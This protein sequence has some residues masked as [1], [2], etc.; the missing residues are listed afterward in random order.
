MAPVN[1]PLHSA[2]RVRVDGKFFRAGTA[3][4]HPRGVAY[5]PLGPNDHGEVF[6]TP[7]ATLRDFGL[8]RALG[9]NVI[10]IYAVPPAWFMDLA[11]AHEL[12]L[13]VD[14][15]WNQRACVLD[16]AASRRRVRGQIHQAAR[17]CARHPAIF[18][19]SVA[20]ELPPD[21]VRWSGP[22]PMEQFLEE[23]AATVKGA[24]PE[25]L[26]TFGNYPT[27]EYLNPRALDFCCFNVYLHDRRALRQYLARLQTLAGE[28]PLL[29]GEFGMD[30]RRE[31]AERQARLLD[32]TIESGFRAGL[33]G[34]IAYTF[35]DEWFKDGQPITDWEFGLTTRE[36]VPRPAFAT[37]QAAYRV[38]PYFPARSEPL[39]SVVVASYNGSRLLRPCLESLAALNYPA[40]EVILVDDGSTDDTP[41][42]AAQYPNVRWIRH[43]RNRG[44]SAARN[45]G[46]AAARGEIVAF[47]DD[48]C[49]VDEDWLHH[50]VGELI[51]SGFAGVG[52][53]NL[54]PGEDSSV[55]AAVLVSP[56]GPTHVMLTDRLAEHIPGC[57]MAFWKSALIEIGCFDPVFT[58]AGD[59]VDLCWRLQQQGLQLG[60]SPGGF[61]WHARRATVRAYLRQQ[62]GYGEAEA[63]LAAKHPEYFNPLG[64]SLWRGQIYTHA[65]VGLQVQRPMIYHGRFGA[66]A[67]QSLYA[68]SPSLAVFVFT[69]LEF[70][71][72]V[73][74]PLLVLS[75]VVGWL[76][77]LA[78]ACVAA[79]V[80]VCGVAA[81]QAV[82]P[83]GKERFWSRPLVGLLYMLQPLVRGWARYQGRLFPSRTS[84]ARRENLDSLSRKQA[85][86]APRLMDFEDVAYRGRQAFL[87]ALVER[88]A[89]DNWQYRL[90]TGWGNW[91]LEVYGDR[92]SK[93][94]IIT[95]AEQP[96]E[97]WRRV[98]C[99]LSTSW[100]LP[101]K[102]AYGLVLAAALLAMAL[103][104]AQ[105]WL[106][107]IPLVA[108]AL[109][110]WRFRVN[111]RNLRR[112]MSVVLEEV[113]VGLGMR[114]RGDR[115]QSSNAT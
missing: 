12:R 112:V 109:A 95:V 41:A 19:L 69:S 110:A 103:W 40:Y 48:D 76:L 21:L 101:A 56:G 9:A 32:W 30:A 71:V 1:A 4:F 79:S 82:L 99:R 70:H 57:N 67:F 5:G 107:W 88:L 24:A 94:R 36:R 114:P 28:K 87:D 26:C 44:L 65:K 11:V 61:V 105:D 91:D 77:P 35:T 16:S 54:A 81:W 86:L 100:P 49:R 33:A 42:I 90:D 78:L 96:D 46:I 84:L 3:K 66:G 59:D 53:H 62:H 83:P 60:F 17:A 10:R 64:G 52:G 74:L 31:G 97:G 50:L 45:S 8:I 15:P 73:T 2:G 37:V 47:T 27:T 92:W 106:A 113:A 6:G 22:E 80:A 63:L 104:R 23:L 43:E 55:A 68:T 89:A 93:L 34:M 14:V 58:R 7:D 85:R 115:P 72:L 98:R 29:L 38:A 111:Q 25:C 102:L 20:N 18:A 51:E 108:P 13:M 39:V 75:A